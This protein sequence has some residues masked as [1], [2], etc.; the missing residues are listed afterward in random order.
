VTSS[1][2]PPISY[3]VG[4]VS[5]SNPDRLRITMLVYP[6]WAITYLFCQAS[7]ARVPHGLLRGS[8]PGIVIMRTQYD[9]PMSHLIYVCGNN[10]TNFTNIDRNTNKWGK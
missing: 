7:D 5:E 1:R 2:A 3:I 4:S 10:I 8:I 9:I 6:L